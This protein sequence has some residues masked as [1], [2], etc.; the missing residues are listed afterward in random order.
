MSAG[1]VEFQGTP[2][3]VRAGRLP[4][5]RQFVYGEPDGPV[6]FHYPAPDYRKDLLAQ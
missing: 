5:L 6:P 3:E 2:D 4:S 1:K